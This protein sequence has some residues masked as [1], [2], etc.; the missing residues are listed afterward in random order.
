MKSTHARL[1]LLAR[2]SRALAIVVLAALAP[3]LAGCYGGFPLTK[4][5][6]EFN[7]K[8]TDN[9]YVHTAVFWAFLVFPVYRAR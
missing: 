4:T 7:G 8:V 3:A 5:I 9:K 2:P 6:Y 1:R